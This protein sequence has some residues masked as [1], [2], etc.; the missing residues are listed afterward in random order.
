M[1]QSV[2]NW[3]KQW[4]SYFEWVPVEKYLQREYI[5]RCNL[6]TCT[7]LARRCHIYEPLKVP[8]FAQNHNDVYTG[9]RP[10]HLPRC[11]S[12]MARC[13]FTEAPNLARVRCDNVSSWPRSWR[14]GKGVIC[15]AN[16]NNLSLSQG[17]CLASCTFCSSWMKKKNGYFKIS[18]TISTII[19]I[20]GGVKERLARW[21]SG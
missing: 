21:Y 5:C 3:C 8:S 16:S 19:L 9:P 15:H 4:K 1:T 7:T 2:A 17:S 12:V 14:G 20:C 13:N 11:Q 6:F 18:I 10:R